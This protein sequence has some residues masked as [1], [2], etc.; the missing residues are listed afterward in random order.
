[1]TAALTIGARVCIPAHSVTGRI[2]TYS[3]E[4][5]HRQV[6]IELADGSIMTVREA[7]VADDDTPPPPVPEPGH[8]LDLVVFA[9]D[10]ARRTQHATTE[11]C[12]ALNA[13]ARGYLF[14]TG[15]SP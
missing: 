7:D 1:M 14:A 3:G 8:V 11:E 6:S 4:A 10:L 9:R 2:V 5:P 13:L 15:R 12:Q